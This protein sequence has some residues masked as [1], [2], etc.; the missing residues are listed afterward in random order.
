[1][2]IFHV[3]TSTV[4]LGVIISSMVCA[5]SACSSLPAAVSG[6]GVP[7]FLWPVVPI[8][9]VPGAME[10]KGI[11]SLKKISTTTATTI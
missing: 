7:V 4:S 11:F 1:M 2:V 9:V 8:F 5:T 3:I 6:L 10:T